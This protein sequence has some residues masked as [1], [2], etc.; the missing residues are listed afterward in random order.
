MEENVREIIPQLLQFLEF[1]LMRALGSFKYE[2][3]L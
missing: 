2:T 1:D 3:T